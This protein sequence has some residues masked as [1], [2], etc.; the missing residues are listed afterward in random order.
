MNYWRS[1]TFWASALIGWFV[2]MLFLAVLVSW[3]GPE[4]MT[5]AGGVIVII[6]QQLLSLLAGYSYGRQQVQQR[7]R[8]QAGFPVVTKDNSDSA[9]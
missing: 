8:K 3:L 9:K 4:E 1:G 6:G 2:T 5:T 7:Q